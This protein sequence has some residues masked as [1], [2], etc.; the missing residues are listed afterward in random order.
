MNITLPNSL[1][2]II[3]SHT[4]HGRRI[5]EVGS[6]GGLHIE[7]L[8]GEIHIIDLDL[9]KLKETESRRPDAYTY[10]HDLSVLP[11][12][13]QGKFDL[14]LC[15]EVL[16]H[17]ERDDALH[18]LA[19]LESLSVGAIVLSTP[20]VTEFTQL[21]RFLIT[22]DLPYYGSYTIGE[23]IIY[24]LKHGKLFDPSGV[25]QGSNSRLVTS[26]ELGRHKTS[27]SHH[28]FTAR[29]YRVSGGAS[30][31]IFEK[32][33]FLKSIRRILEKILLSKRIS[34]TVFAWRDKL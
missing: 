27:F 15:L 2:K 11:L 8:V 10:R 12:P 9:D 18:L 22:R 14:I 30:N 19:E 1:N 25:N 24:F 29:G 20:N 33:P 23:K 13:V 4:G 5:L 6:S 32:I 31:Y 34:G 3:T 7:D 17:L 28:F 16:E 21:L 26:E